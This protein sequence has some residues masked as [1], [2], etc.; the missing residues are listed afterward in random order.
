MRLSGRSM[1]LWVKRKTPVP[2]F[3]LG[4]GFGHRGRIGKAPAM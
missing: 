4:G 3:L 1:Q 2:D